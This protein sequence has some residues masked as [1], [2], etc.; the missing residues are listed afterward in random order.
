M[1]IA[2]AVAM[3]AI[4]LGLAT[5]PLAHA[6][7]PEAA[8]DSTDPSGLWHTHSD[9]AGRPDSLVRLRLQADGSASAV[10]ERILDEAKR[11]ARC[12]QCPGAA[13]GRPIEG[14]EILS[15]MHRA[16]SE[17]SGGQIL[18]PDSGKVYS[19]RMRLSPD[20]HTLEVRGFIGFSLLGRSQT[21][22]REPEGLQ[23]R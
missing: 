10:I 18:D 7:P 12:E 15:G 20:G 8:A 9:V 6:A 19:C 1:A 2:T 5:S 17:I 13:L 16:G 21:W 3:A 11:T 23:S 22:V 4:A 14:L